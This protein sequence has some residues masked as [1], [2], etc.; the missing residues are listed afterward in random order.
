MNSYQTIIDEL[1]KPSVEIINPVKKQTV[2]PK[3]TINVA[4][5]VPFKNEQYLINIKGQ[6]RKEHLEAFK[7]HM[8]PFSRQM[9]ENARSKN[10]DLTV[11]IYI[12]EQTTQ[13]LKFNRGALINAGVQYAQNKKKYISFIIH[14]V[15]LL[16]KITS[17]EDYLLSTLDNVNESIS[18]IHLAKTWNRYKNIERF[19]GGVLIIRE[20]FFNEING[21]PNF[22]EGWG[23]EDEAFIRRIERHFD[24]LS[25]TTKL[26]DILIRTNNTS[27]QDLEEIETYTEKLNLMQSNDILVN[28]DIQGSLNTDVIHSKQSG[29]NVQNLFKLINESQ[30]DNFHIIEIELNREYVMLKNFI[31]ISGDDEDD[32]DNIKSIIIDTNQTNQPELRD[33]KYLENTNNDSITIVNN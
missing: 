15:D 25:K 2:I 28:T 7:K 4:I 23:T 18:L 26:D 13:E 9:I 14:D 33:I 16:P 5:I 21:Y 27:F 6:N 11:D 20:S 10:I 32:D 22:F 19:I 24:D 1:N 12:I 30:D 31:Y 29:L 3:H 8:K 17:V